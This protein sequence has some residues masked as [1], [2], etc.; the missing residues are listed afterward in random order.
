MSRTPR[1]ALIAWADI[2]TSVG[3]GSS[4]PPAAVS[5]QRCSISTE[6]RGGTKR[7]TAMPDPMRSR[8]FPPGFSALIGLILLGAGSNRA[9]RASPLQKRVVAA[10]LADGAD[11][12]VAAVHEEVV[13]LGQE[14]RADALQQRLAVAVGE[15]GA[16]DRAREERVAGEEGVVDGEG[17]P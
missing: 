3:A 4:R 16:A 11:R 13:G 8:W 9:R 10:L 14:L 15:V 2:G 17:D 12:A 6:V 5:V 7:R 1:A